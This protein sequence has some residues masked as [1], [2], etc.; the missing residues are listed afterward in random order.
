MRL[1]SRKIRLLAT[2]QSRSLS[3]LL[4]DADV[5]RTAFYSLARRGSLLPRTVHAIAETLGVRPGDLLEMSPPPAAQILAR[6]LAQARAFVTAHPDC[7]FENVWHILAL[8]D[9]PPIERLNRSLTRGRAITVH[10]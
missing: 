6:R 10:R 3:A 5:S 4:R 2:R 9:M 8:L 7:L 1:S